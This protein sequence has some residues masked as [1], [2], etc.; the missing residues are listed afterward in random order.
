MLVRHNYSTCVCNRDMHQSWSKQACGVRNGCG[1]ASNVSELWQSPG[2]ADVIDAAS[3]VGTC[4]TDPAFG[5]AEW[6]AIALRHA[7][8]VSG[9]CHGCINEACARSVVSTR[10]TAVRVIR[11]QSDTKA[12]K[13]PHPLATARPIHQILHGPL[14]PNARGLQKKNRRLGHTMQHTTKPRTLKQRL[15]WDRT[16]ITDTQ[17]MATA[18]LNNRAILSK[19][20]CVKQT[21]TK[22]REV[23]VDL[24]RQTL[25]GHNHKPHT[26]IN[27]ES[28]ALHGKQQHCIASSAQQ[29]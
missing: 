2:L 15:H 16:Q 25:R 14:Q 27:T 21:P 13:R 23:R 6:V 4:T 7:Q 5:V 12:S 26:H 8:S 22:H 18:A 10:I 3:V 11:S 1:A 28:R 19:T 20:A 29:L 24:A 9:W 17:A